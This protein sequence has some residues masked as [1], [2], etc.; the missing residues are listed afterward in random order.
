MGSIG[1]AYDNALCEGFFATLECELL[2][3]ERFRMAAEACRAVFDYIEGWIGLLTPAMVHYGDAEAVHARRREI[4][5]A[6]YAQH[7]ARFVRKPPQPPALPTAV[8]INPPPLATATLEA[9]Q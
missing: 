5:A 6:A 9:R 2:D 7:P 3:R 8:W 1:D 4:L